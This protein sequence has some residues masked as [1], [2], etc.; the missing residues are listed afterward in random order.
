MAAHFSSLSHL[1]SWLRCKKL[2]TTF[3]WMKKKNCN[4]WCAITIS[5]CYAYNFLLIS[6]TDAI[7]F[8]QISDN[9]MAIICFLVS[10]SA[11]LNEDGDK[12]SQNSAKI[13]I[14]R[15]SALD[16]AWFYLGGN[17]YFRAFMVPGW[18]FGAFSHAYTSFSISFLGW[19]ESKPLSLPLSNQNLFISLLVTLILIIYGKRK[20]PEIISFIHNP[21]MRMLIQE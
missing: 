6:V 7:K 12:K 11:N 2:L 10:F 19:I 21:K 9:S 4:I 15:M 13:M 16:N 20:W 3:E 5:T 17:I 18:N 1:Y 8:K 14:Y